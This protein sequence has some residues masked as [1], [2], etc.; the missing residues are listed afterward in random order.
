MT[1]QARTG[2][3]SRGVVTASRPRPVRHDLVGTPP[4]STLEASSCWEGTP[5]WDGLS[6][7]ASIRWSALHPRPDHGPGRLSGHPSPAEG[8]PLRTS[9]GHLW[10]MP[11][12]PTDPRTVQSVWPAGARASK[13]QREGWMFE[14]FV[15][16]RVDVGEAELRVRHGGSGPRSCCRTAI[17]APMRPGTRS[18]RYWPGTAP[19][20]ARTCAAMA[21]RPSRRPA[22]TTRLLQTGDGTR[23]RRADADAGL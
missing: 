18:L 22:P 11:G 21:S 1:A 23:L 12:P 6:E 14:G 4:A 15:L 3:Q 13:E 8:S 16:E 10:G 2:H 20:S 19:W 5:C 9:P 7:I 17:P